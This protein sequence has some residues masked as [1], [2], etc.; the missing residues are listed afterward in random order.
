MSEKWKFFLCFRKKFALDSEKLN[1]H[2]KTPK[3]EYRRTFKPNIHR[4]IK[5]EKWTILDSETKDLNY[6]YGKLKMSKETSRPG[7]FGLIGGNNI[8]YH[9]FKLGF[10]GSSDIPTKIQEKI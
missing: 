5:N 1:A 9:R 4:K 7:Y 2:K 3:V 10:Y 6:A 8:G